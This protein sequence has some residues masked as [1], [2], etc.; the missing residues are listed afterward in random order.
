MYKHGRMKALVIEYKRIRNLKGREFERF[1]MWLYIKYSNL[2]LK[3]TSGY[4]KPGYRVFDRA[5]F[6]R[7]NKLIVHL[8][9]YVGPTTELSFLILCA[10]IG[11]LD[12]Y[13]YGIVVGANIY[14]ILIYLIQTSRN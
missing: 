10:F 14:V 5:T 13:L 7:K 3:F 12:L 11:R 1:L 4:A 8:W 9:T 2:Q 6:I